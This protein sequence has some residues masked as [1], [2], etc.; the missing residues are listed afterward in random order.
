MTD[1][2]PTWTDA[3]FK[4]T[5]DVIGKFGDAKVTYAVFMRRPVVSA[6][7][8][9][10]EWLKRVAKDRDFEVKVD[11]RYAEGRWSAPVRR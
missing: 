10:L 11:L 5:R 8:L 4:R 7:R 9:A 2:I 1:T 6:P 3:Y